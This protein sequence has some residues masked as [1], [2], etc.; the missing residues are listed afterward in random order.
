MALKNSAAFFNSL[1]I[2]LRQTSTEK[3]LLPQRMVYDS[4]DVQL[5]HDLILVNHNHQ[6]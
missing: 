1:Q 2:S 6:L 4:K 5:F 3:L